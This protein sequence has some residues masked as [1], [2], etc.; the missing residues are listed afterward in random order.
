MDP[1]ASVDS[2]GLLRALVGVVDATGVGLAA[3][4]RHL[5]RLDHE[6]CAHVLGHRPA[7]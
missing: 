7:D 3:H 2:Y 4:D 5:K 1:A 6:L